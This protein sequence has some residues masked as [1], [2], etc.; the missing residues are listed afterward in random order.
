MVANEDS[1]SPVFVSF[2]A[3]SINDDTMGCRVPLRVTSSVVSTN[4]WFGWHGATVLHK[5]SMLSSSQLNACDIHRTMSI[6]TLASVNQ[7][8]RTSDW[9]YVAMNPD[10]RLVVLQLAARRI[11]EQSRLFNGYRV[12]PANLMRRICNQ[13]SVRYHVS[14]L[15]SLQA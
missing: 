15:L 10:K 13:H 6:K 2:T 9:S 4:E 7:T 1:D 8:V 5:R 12:R 11:C 3:S 14:H